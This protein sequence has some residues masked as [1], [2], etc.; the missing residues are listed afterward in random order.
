MLTP[1]MN[2][3]PTTTTTTTTPRVP[4]AAS[5][6]VIVDEL[7]DLEFGCDYEDL[8]V[9]VQSR[10]YL[11]AQAQWLADPARWDGTPNTP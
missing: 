9:H 8:P 6:Q 5:I 4:T 10:L 3:V 7:A 1:P 11:T 2:T